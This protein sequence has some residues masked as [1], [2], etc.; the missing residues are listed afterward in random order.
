MSW[1]MEAP[2]CLFLVY[3]MC[4]R[5]QVITLYTR[6]SPSDCFRDSCHGLGFQYITKTHTHCIDRVQSSIFSIGMAKYCTL[7]ASRVERTTLS[8]LLG[9][10]RY[11][12]RMRIGLYQTSPLLCNL[13][14]CLDHSCQ[15]QPCPSALMYSLA[16]FPT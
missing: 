5:R 6:S 9:L 14:C 15:R 16:C 4:Y 10:T 3:A 11:A 8:S 1:S 7:S 2:S 12:P 13:I